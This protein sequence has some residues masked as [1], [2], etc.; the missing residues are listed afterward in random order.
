MYN[1]CQTVSPDCRCTYQCKS[2]ELHS[3]GDPRPASCGDGT[4]PDALSDDDIYEG[5]KKVPQPKANKKRHHPKRKA[6]S[7][8]KNQQKATGNATK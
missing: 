5:F 4:G 7:A 2:C 8:K 6:K 1:F 3:Q